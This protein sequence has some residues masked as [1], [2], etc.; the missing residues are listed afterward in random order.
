MKHHW[1]RW[2][3]GLMAVVM[4]ITVLAATALA[5]VGDLVRRS[6]VEN[7]AL[8]QALEEAYGG[9][10]QAYLDVLEQY[11]LLD[12]DGNFVTDAKIVMNGTAFTLDQIEMILDDPDTD[13]DTVVEVDGQF[14]TL[15]ELKT[16]VEIER[17]LAYIKATYFTQQDLTDQQIS[18][19]YDLAAAWAAGGVQMLAANT[20]DGV[21]PAGV[22]HGVTLSVRALGSASVNGTYTVTVTASNS[23]AAPDQE[24][25]FDWRAVSGNVNATGGG[26]VTMHPGESQTLTVDVGEAQGYVDGEGTFLVQIYNVKNALFSD[27]STRWENVRGQRI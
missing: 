8:L 26:T 11:G 16:V 1:K 9:D 17:Y 5:A 27:G 14:L 10:A 24:I 3:A 7:A 6:G 15:G 21:G 25:T 12:G 2:L 23:T 13:L 20:L 4:M 22:D 19:F 18:S